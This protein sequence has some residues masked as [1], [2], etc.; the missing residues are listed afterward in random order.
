MEIRFMKAK[1][2][3]VVGAGVSGLSAGRMLQEHGY[4][5]TIFEKDTRPGGLIKCTVENGN[6]Y[7]R[8]G[9]HVFN[10]N[11]QDVLDWFWNIFDKD[12][13][14][15]QATRN[16]A[17]EIEN[18]RLIGAPVEDHIYQ[19][20][21]EVQAAI[22]ND[23]L[24]LVAAPPPPADNFEDFLRRRFGETLYDIYFGPYNNKIWRKSLRDVPLEWLEGKL[25]TPSVQDI[26][27]SNI[28]QKGESN[29]VHSKFYYPKHGGSQF[30]ADTLAKGLNII[31]DTDI[32]QL[33][34][35][36]GRWSISGNEYEAV[37]FTGNIKSLPKLLAETSINLDENAIEDLEYHG[38]TTVL[39]KVESNP[40]SW[41]YLPCLEHDSHR[42]ICTGN[43]APG[44][45]A[46]N[47]STATI[48]FSTEMSMGE[49]QDNLSKLPFHPEY[50]AHHHQKYTY[51]M[52]NQLTADTIEKA[53][54]ALEP[55]NLLLI[56]R[57]AEWKYYNMDTA[58]GA[59]IDLISSGK[60]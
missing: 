23:L 26:L 10:S 17:I 41:V 60:L 48:E 55:N 46:P 15:L 12:A 54:N 27:L 11:R 14:F 51:P 35:R 42:I 6:L 30:I 33:E 2:I 29:F 7:H 25:P 50:I 19:M 9:G 39:C 18:Q 58:M 22:V 13:D 59:C 45:N 31:K 3:A 56:G 1:K 32:T 40:H 24:G 43:F 47:I 44:N 20:R 21:P 52:Q 16:S 37:V 34:Y 5:V 53:R 49:I 8:I 57:F 4:D 28:R 38:T 36:E